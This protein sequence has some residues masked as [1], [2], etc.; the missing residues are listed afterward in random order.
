LLH[1]HQDD[2]GEDQYCAIKE[3]PSRQICFFLIVFHKD[4]VL[5][6]NIFSG[7]HTVLKMSKNGMKL[8]HGHEANLFKKKKKKKKKKKEGIGTC[9]CWRIGVTGG[10][11]IRD[12]ELPKS[13]DADALFD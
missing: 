13:E 11:H 8:D 4:I 6:N 7:N 9:I 3:D 5:E 12:A 1:G 10:T 2:T